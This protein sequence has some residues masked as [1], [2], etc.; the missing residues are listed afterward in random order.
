MNPVLF[1]RFTLFLF[2]PILRGEARAEVPEVAAP[3]LVG[4]RAL[5]LLHVGHV[6]FADL[7]DR[8]PAGGY[9]PG[10]FL[11]LRLLGVIRPFGSVLGL[12][13]L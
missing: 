3:H 10:S 6:G 11:L 5:V 7:P 1:G 8:D 2:T 12:G 9:P 13:K 4:A